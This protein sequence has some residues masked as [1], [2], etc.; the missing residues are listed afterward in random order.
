[1]QWIPITCL[2]VALISTDDPDSDP[3]VVRALEAVALAVAKDDL[4][5]ARTEAKHAVEV[6]KDRLGLDHKWTT[7]AQLALADAQWRISVK[8]GDEEGVEIWIDEA[9][10]FATKSGDPA[11]KHDWAERAEEFA[12]RT[13]PPGDPAIAEAVVNRAA[14][15]W[16]RAQQADDAAELL[17]QAED[18]ALAALELGEPETARVWAEAGRRVAVEALARENPRRLRLELLVCE[19]RWLTARTSGDWETCRAWT[20]RARGFLGPLRDEAIEALWARRSEETNRG[21]A[22]FDPKPAIARALD[23]FDE[24]IRRDDLATAREH[25]TAADRMAAERLGPE[26]PLRARAAL[27][28]ADAQWRISVASGAMALACSWAGEARRAAVDA[29]DLELAASWADRAE[30]AALESAKPGDPTLTCAALERATIR[31]GLAEAAGEQGEAIDQASDAVRAALSLDD[32]EAAATWVERGQGVLAGAD[33]GEDDPRTVR[34]ALWGAVVRGWEALGRGD[35]TSAEAALLGVW[36]RAEPILPSGD[37]A[38]SQ[39]MG[40]AA[41]LVDEPDEA[42]A[43]YRKIVEET[44]GHEAEAPRVRVVALLQIAR[45][46]A[47]RDEDD[48]EASARALVEAGRLLSTRDA[49]MTLACRAVDRPGQVLTEEARNAASDPAVEATEGIVRAKLAR[50]Q[51]RLIEGGVDPAVAELTGLRLAYY[52]WQR[53]RPDE[54]EATLNGLEPSIARGPIPPYFAG[55]FWNLR[56]LIDLERARFA[57]ARDAFEKAEA[58]FR[59]AAIQPE[60]AIVLNNLGLLLLRQGD[61]VAAGAYLR[62]AVSYFDDNPLAETRVDHARAL[63]NLAKTVEIEDPAAAEALHTRALELLTS[64]AGDDPEVTSTIVVCRNNLGISAYTVGEIDRAAEAF[65]R[66]RRDA[67]AS[68][69]EGHFHVAEIDVNLGWIALARGHAEDAEALFDRSLATFRAELGDDHPR[70]A[71]VLSYRAR[72]L[73]DLGRAEEARKDLVEALALRRQFLARALGSSLSERDRLAVVQELRVHPESSAWPGVLDTYLE[74]AT[75]VGASTTEQYRELLAWKGILAR[76]APTSLE[77]LED[78]EEIRDVAGRYELALRE[79]HRAAFEAEGPNRA[80]ALARSE[81]LAEDLERQLRDLSPRFALG[82]EEEVATP[83][84]VAGALPGGAVLLDVIEIREFHQSE[85]G[86]PPGRSRY[87]GFLVRP[88]RGEPIRLDLGDSSEL[89]DYIAQFR[90]DL[91]AGRGANTPVAE[92]LAGLVRDRLAPDLVGASTLIVAGDGLFHFLPLAALPIRGPG[93]FWAEDLAFAAVPTAES[94]LRRRVQDDADPSASGALIVGGVDYGDTG[95]DNPFVPLAATLGEAREVA[96]A[97]ARAFPDRR[98]SIRL[99]TGPDATG[100]AIRPLLPRS[101]IVHL[102][103]HG[104]FQ[105]SGTVEAFGVYGA[106]ARF[107]SRVALADANFGRPTAILTADEVG[108][109]DLHRTDLVVLSACESGLGHVRAGQGTIGLFGAFDRAG[110]R[111]VVGSL[112]EVADAPTA[113]LMKAFY[114]HLWTESPTGGPVG[115][116]AALRAAQLD[117]IHGRVTDADGG[118][119]ADPRYWS[120]FILEGDPA[121]P[122]RRPG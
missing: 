16:E 49:A 12:R 104:R 102:A 34:V 107:D 94:I 23:G 87:L 85:F 28:H 48:V 30:A 14:A 26:D 84:R 103:T 88:D 72:T 9:Y 82:V 46:V 74:L 95:D 116:A 91:E 112:W 100:E 76:H 1:M 105:A 10:R 36:E 73:I 3:E 110:A 89:N 57:R 43:R 93:T 111:T 11:A 8:L 64:G 114:R 71:E 51:E 13:K 54:A 119:L 86:E 79:L 29:D 27:A 56:G 17:V 35:S 106:S 120:T 45:L 32:L 97:Y 121:A 33:L 92:A 68:Y 22:E 98:G 60:Q 99:L 69:G 118:S 61:R 77:D 40:L 78:H 38:R 58:L 52:Q 101:R 44:E 41:R 108:R 109:M 75:R 31:F 62:I 90:A 53:R 55:H 117:L 7:K 63:T 20:D 70:T 18:A 25:A 47:D 80:S 122:P 50:I 5:T 115:P 81:D 65:T 24:A 19:A 37:P 66:A 113:A 15:G 21:L 42:L 96:E 39:A 83:E 67:V 4:T 6:A 59:D 2:A